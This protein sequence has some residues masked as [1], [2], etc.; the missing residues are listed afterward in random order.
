MEASKLPGFLLRR[1]VKAAIVVLALMVGALAMHLK[2]GDPMMKS[3]PAALMLA[4]S[5]GWPVTSGRP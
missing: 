3:V 5:T 1:G 2:V 4:M